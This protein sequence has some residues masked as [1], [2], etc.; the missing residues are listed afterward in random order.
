MEN[1]KTLMW[2]LVIIISILFLFGGW[3]MGGMM[4]FGLA[5]PIMLVFW[6]LVIWMIVSLVNKPTEKMRSPKQILQE[7]YAKGDITKSEYE[8]KKKE[9]EN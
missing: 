4:G 6:A 7:R 8:E 5:A 2:A 1:D 3:G 9:L